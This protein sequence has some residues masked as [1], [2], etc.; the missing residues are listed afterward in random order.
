MEEVVSAV[1][2]SDDGDILTL[3]RAPYKRHYPN[4][5]DTVTGKK[6]PNESDEDCL[7][8]EVREE[9][10]IENFA[11]K[12][13]LEKIIH[14]DAGREWSA[15]I[16]LCNFKNGDIA[17]NEEHS[18]YKWMPLSKIREENCSPPFLKELKIIFANNIQ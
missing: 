3:K 17:L 7:M 13:R 8:R 12:H 14:K 10:G 1:F 5:W 18:E 6:E 4:M 2:A 15:T 9:L 11:I 16:F